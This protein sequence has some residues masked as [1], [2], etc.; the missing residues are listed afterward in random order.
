DNFAGWLFEFRTDTFSDGDALSHGIAGWPELFSESFADEHDSGRS[1]IVAIGEQTSADERNL[2][3]F[4]I[5]GG[6]RF[7][8]AA[9]VSGSLPQW[10]AFDDERQPQSALQRQAARLCDG[11]NTRQAFDTALRFAHEL[12]DAGSLVESRRRKRHLHGQDVVGVEA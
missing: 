10:P 9:A 2:E 11:H 7:P 4:E 12:L 8:R 1:S 5:A 3:D 6:D